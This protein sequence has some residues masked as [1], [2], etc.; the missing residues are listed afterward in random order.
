[1]EIFAPL[2][3][4]GL[5]GLLEGHDVD[6]PENLGVHVL[7]RQRPPPL[8]FPPSELVVVSELAAEGA[9]QSFHFRHRL[10]GGFVSLRT[11]TRPCRAHHS[12]TVA[13]S[14]PRFQKT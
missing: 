9:L 7:P 14:Q 10:T 1:M 3:V 4:G 13:R 11:R 2:G 5:A 6:A 12:G 8:R